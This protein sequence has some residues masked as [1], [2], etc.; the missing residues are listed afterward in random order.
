MT[1]Q[2]WPRWRLILHRK[3]EIVII[4][5]TN[6]TP[7]VR[8]FY[9]PPHP[10][11]SLHRYCVLPVFKANEAT[12]IGEKL[13]EGFEDTA[14]DRAEGL[15]HRRPRTNHLCRFLLLRSRNYLFPFFVG[16]HVTFVYFVCL[17]YMI[18]LAMKLRVFFRLN[19]GLWTLNNDCHATVFSLKTTWQCM[20]VNLALTREIMCVCGSINKKAKQKKKTK[21]SIIRWLQVTSLL[22]KKVE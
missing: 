20:T 5:L 14:G 6:L 9:P 11:A 17:Q 21:Q 7:T 19:D 13:K 3:L 8:S 10:S 15:S 12:R 22:D 2:K 1:S 16:L 18:S 4:W